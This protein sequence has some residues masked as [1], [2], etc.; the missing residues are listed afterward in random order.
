M[1]AGK[2]KIVEFID[3][4]LEQFSKHSTEDELESVTN[5]HQEQV[6]QEALRQAKER[7]QNRVRS[8]HQGKGRRQGLQR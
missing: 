1:I 4:Q 7:I 6:E 8:S 2:E 5:G 3:S